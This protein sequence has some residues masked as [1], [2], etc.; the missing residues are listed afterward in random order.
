MR[1]VRTL[2]PIG[3][4]EAA[5]GFGGRSLILYQRET[6]VTNLFVTM[7]HRVGV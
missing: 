6:P 7:L 3:I 1:D 4:E 5:D 2:E